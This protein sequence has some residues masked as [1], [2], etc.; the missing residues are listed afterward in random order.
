[1]ALGGKRTGAGNKEGSIRPKF[2]NYLSEEKIQL[3]IDKSYERAMDG[4][5]VLA[6]FILEQHFGKAMQPVEGNM[7][8]NITLTFDGAF[9][10]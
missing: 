8:G 2:S 7:Q 4:D 10:Q 3:L 5:S 1:M 6:K 9:K